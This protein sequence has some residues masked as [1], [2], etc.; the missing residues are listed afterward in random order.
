[1]PWTRISW[2]GA[3]CIQLSSFPLPYWQQCLACTLLS[4]GVPSSPRSSATELCSFPGIIYL[5]C[6]S[7]RGPL[8]RAVPAGGRWDAAGPRR[9]PAAP[10]ARPRRQR[11]AGARRLRCAPPVPGSGGT[12]TTDVL[13]YEI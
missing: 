3:P 11:A 10:V 12:P 8:G 5:V 9:V 4:A 7:I 13:M 1:M 2:L 6:S